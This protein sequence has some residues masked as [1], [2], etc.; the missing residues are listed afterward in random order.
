M[1]QMQRQAVDR[2]DGLQ[3]CVDIAG[4][5]EIVAVEMQRVRQAEIARRLGQRGHDATGR[6]AVM[7]ACALETEIAAR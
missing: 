4:H 5:A 1:G 6:Q 3:G 7:R 2:A